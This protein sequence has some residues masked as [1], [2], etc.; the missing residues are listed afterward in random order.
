MLCK[1]EI[2]SGAIDDYTRAIAISPKPDLYFDRGFF[3][4]QLKKYAE[5][6]ADFD[7]A[8]E[9]HVADEQLAKHNRGICY[10]FLNEKENA[11]KDW[12]SSGEV[13]LD[14]LNKYCTG[15]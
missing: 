11:C 6:K 3:N 1:M 4:M 12:K 15:N 7:K 14:F 13:S 8:L 9:L 2:Y 5:A 10:Y